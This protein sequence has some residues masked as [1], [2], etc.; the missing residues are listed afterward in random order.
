M[1]PT[2]STYLVEDPERERRTARLIADAPGEEAILNPLGIPIGGSWFLLELQKGR[3]F[4][5]ELGD[6]D[7]LAGRLDWG[8]PTEFQRALAA[9]RKEVK[10][11]G[12]PSTIAFLAAQRLANDGG[13]RWPPPTDWLVAIELKCAYLSPKAPHISREHV[14][15]VKPSAQKV[16]HLRQQVSDLL[17]LGVNRVALVD[18]IANPPVSGPDG[19]AWVTAAAVAS[20]TRRTMACDLD[21]RL[22]SDSPVG[23]CAYTIGAV[24]GGDESRRAASSAD[25]RRPPLDNPLLANDPTVRA[26]RREVEANLLKIFETIQRPL[27][28]RV[29]YRD[30]PGC[31]RLHLEGQPCSP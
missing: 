23:H 12:H 26:R 22:P 16:A 21:A 19:G 27:N 14:K 29:V 4:T 18:V 20:E 6:I 9:V 24:D 13:L 10:G 8:D 7:I 15:S 1:P 11:R 2:P 5:A 30:C 25:W 17:K 31:R 3:L 28:L